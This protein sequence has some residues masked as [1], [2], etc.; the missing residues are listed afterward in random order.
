[1]SPY[2]N[3][4]CVTGCTAVTNNLNLFPFTPLRMLF[5]FPLDRLC[6][7]FCEC[8]GAGAKRLSL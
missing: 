8:L 2:K 5:L 3:V 1:M 7:G 6:L 4:T